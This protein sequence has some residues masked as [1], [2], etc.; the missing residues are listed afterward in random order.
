MF[1]LDHLLELGLIPQSCHADLSQWSRH[2]RIPFG[3]LAVHHGLLTGEDIDSILDA[4]RS[5][6]KLFGELAIEMGLLRGAHVPVLL[7]IQAF[8]CACS[9]AQGVAL[10]G[11]MSLP[12]VLAE[13]GDLMATDS[14]RILERSC[15]AVVH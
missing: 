11:A 9:V 13:L 15:K 1:F 6:F 2:S 10:S 3:M 12:A 8:Q 7:D 4:Q 5:S 14:D